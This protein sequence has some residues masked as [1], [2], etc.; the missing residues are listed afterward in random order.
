MDPTPT[1]SPDDTQNITVI[2][3]DPFWGNC[4]REV[5]RPVTSDEGVTSTEVVGQVVTAE[6]VPYLAQNI[7][8]GATTFAG[9][10]AVLFIIWGGFKLAKGS[11]DPKE[12]EGA[13]NTIVYAIIGL[14]LVF[15]SFFIIN[16]IATVTGVQCIT[17][18]G[19][20]TCGGDFQG[21]RAD[22]QKI[23]T[24]DTPLAIPIQTDNPSS[25]CACDNPA[26]Y[27]N[28]TASS[29]EFQF[30]EYPDGTAYWE[31]DTNNQ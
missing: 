17:F 22:G 12:I 30:R 11:G 23:C 24:P 28:S 10:V 13:R 7:I 1:V 25:Y 8:I 2:E 15:F 3:N 18:F 27:P 4:L 16:V 19:L 9:I 5:T 29:V 20:N 26:D 21:V 6:C 31:C 14:I